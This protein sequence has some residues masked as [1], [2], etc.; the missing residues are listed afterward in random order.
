MVLE[1]AIDF[2][3]FEGAVGGEEGGDALEGA[4]DL[5]DRLAVGADAEGR[6]FSPAFNAVVDQPQEEIGALGGGASAD[7]QGKALLDGEGGEVQFHRWDDR[8]AFA[9][10][11]ACHCIKLRTLKA[12]SD[13]LSETS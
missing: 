5:V 11:L 6:C 7:G 8:R 10:I 1:N 4:G 12:R 2:L 3:G 9:I 13:A